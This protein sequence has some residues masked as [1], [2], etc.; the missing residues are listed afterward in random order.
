MKVVTTLE[1][2]RA[3]RAKLAEPLGFVP[4]MGYLHEGHLS[5]VRQARADCASVVVSIFVNPAQ[6]GPQEDLAAYPRD[7]ERD[8]RLLEGA[9][10]ELVW[11]PTAEVMYPAGYQTWVAVEEVSRPLEGSHAPG[12]FPRGGDGGRQ[13]V[14]RRPA[15]AG[16]LW[17]ERRPAGGGH[18]PHGAVT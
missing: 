4:T 10:V 17:A 12:A 16:I 3:A 14:Q 9:G 18:P 7:L 5:L 11:T 15:A 6:F 1:E 2:L 8:L 13:A